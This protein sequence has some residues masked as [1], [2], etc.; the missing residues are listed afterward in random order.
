MSDSISIGW[1]GPTHNQWDWILGHFHRVT[2]LTDRNVEDWITSQSQA[3]HSNPAN[4]PP[5]LIAAI[6]SRFEPALEFVKSLD[7]SVAANPTKALS[8]PWCVLLGD[9]WVGHRRTYPLPE[10]MPTFYWYEWYDR[11]F[12]WLL[13]QS[14][15]GT[16]KPV[17]DPV[18]STNP[19]KLSPRVQR[20]IDASLSIDNRLR[21]NKSGG[22][23]IKMAMIVTATAT[24][25][26]LWCDALSRHEI[27]CIATTPENLE[28]WAN[29]DMLVVDIE[30]EPWIVRERQQASENGC[31]RGSLIRR[32]ASQFPKATMIV[33]DA[34]PRWD[35]WK[36]LKDCGA[37]FIVAKPF[38]L[39][40]ILDTLEKSQWIRLNHRN[41]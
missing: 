23:S 40:G 32:L 30:S 19:R 12:P 5:V 3:S 16:S 28:L 27:Q 4:S 9:D 26:Q 11:V 18:A 8:L 10:T 38:Q 37:D 41:S 6:E 15:G 22:N 7:P 21:C 29:P 33:A 39:P 20:L 14:Q 1:F 25:R 24:T 35:T 34:F 36:T 13:D 2:L 31:A 17:T